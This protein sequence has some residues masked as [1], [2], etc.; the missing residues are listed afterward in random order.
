MQTEKPLF[1]F[2]GPFLI[3]YSGL[4]GQCSSSSNP[5]TRAV[6]FFASANTLIP[7]QHWTSLGCIFRLLA[8]LHVYTHPGGSSCFYRMGSWKANVGINIVLRWVKS[9]LLT[10][11][12]CKW[13]PRWWTARLLPVCV[14]TSFGILVFQFLF[15]ISSPQ[16]LQRF[17]AAGSS[18][19]E[20]KGA[21][22]PSE[23]HVGASTLLCRPL[24][25]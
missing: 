24:G 11:L 17:Q 20:G 1:P 25:P 13:P 15:P 18:H 8:F 16:G 6:L 7:A 5:S 14:R 22:C 19:P 4:K 21:S 10:W 3:L 12:I 23:K 2:K 9:G